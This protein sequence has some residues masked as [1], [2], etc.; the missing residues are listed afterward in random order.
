MARLGKPGTPLCA[1][2]WAAPLP[3]VPP[4]LVRCLC[5]CG[6]ATAWCAPHNFI[7][8]VHDRRKVL[9]HWMNTGVCGVVGGYCSNFALQRGRLQP[10][11]SELA[12]ISCFFSFFFTD[13]SFMMAPAGWQHVGCNDGGRFCEYHGPTELEAVVHFWTP[14]CLGRG[15]TCDAG[16]A[17][18]TC[19]PL[20]SQVQG[21]GVVMIGTTSVLRQ[22]KC[23]ECDEA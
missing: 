23:M 6:V 3:S 19:C 8:S 14:Q 16:C 22:R 21:G 11:C 17:Q 10:G 13:L 15:L 20:N 1:T 5:G 2:G 4:C 18:R 7:S 12:G 9:A